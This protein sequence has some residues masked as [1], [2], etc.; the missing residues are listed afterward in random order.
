[1][2]LRYG[3]WQ[4]ILHINSKASNYFLPRRSDSKIYDRP[5]DIESCWKT[6]G[7]TRYPIL[8]SRQNYCSIGS[9]DWMFKK[10]WPWLFYWSVI[11]ALIQKE[12]CVFL[13]SNT[14]ICGAMYSCRRT[15]NEVVKAEIIAF[16]Y[17]CFFVSFCCSIF[18]LLI[19]TAWESLLFNILKFLFFLT[20][21]FIL[22]LTEK[23]L[24]QWIHNQYF[25]RAFVLS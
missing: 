18:V 5:W 14:S 6:W 2:K 25:I 24:L 21:K 13:L 3:K 17:V 11:L 9:H 10:N 15:Y 7:H 20:V 8:C 23:S 4:Q 1:M 12:D 19:L 22:L 16:E